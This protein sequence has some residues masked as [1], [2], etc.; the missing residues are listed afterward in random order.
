[1]KIIRALPDY[2]AGE[3][4]LALTM[5]VF[6][7]VHR[8][9]QALLQSVREEAASAG[10]VSAVMTFDP[11]PVL[12]LRPDLSIP[13]LQTISQRLSSFE[14]AG[15]DV[16]IVVPFTAQFAQMEAEEFV[17]DV[18]VKQLRV[19][20]IVL[21]ENFYFG[22]NRTG[23]VTWLRRAGS[24][25]GFRV[26]VCSEKLITGEW[27]SS[28]RIRE[29]VASAQLEKAGEMLGRAYSIAGR[30]MKGNQLGR[31]L[32]FPTMNVSTENNMIIP[33]GVYTAAVR[34]NSQLWPGVASYGL[35][36]SVDDS[37]AAGKRSPL[38][39]VHLF[40]FDREVYGEEIEVF[41]H[42]WQRAE[43]KFDHFIELSAQIRADAAEARDWLRG[44]AVDGLC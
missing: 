40:G 33:F 3:T 32:G 44:H 5:G 28:S 31:K 7:G 20:A 8:G 34:L 22:R 19:C 16:A 1:M 42:H 38:L 39:E 11:H 35:R 10:A 18:L 43:L 17:R 4:K 25:Y 37:R 21:G 23:D 6:D 15:I 12:L 30:V 24:R 26:Q 14:E 2:R 27:I 36:P 29:L 41:L 9:H 13:Q